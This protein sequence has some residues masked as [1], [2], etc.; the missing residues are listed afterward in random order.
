MIRRDSG[1]SVLVDSVP[2]HGNDWNRG[3]VSVSKLK[4]DE[5]TRRVAQFHDQPDPEHLKIA[6]SQV[7]IM[8]YTSSRF[9]DHCWLVVK[10]LV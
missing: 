9:S 7:A 1:F 10:N 5:R 8:S 2:S 3:G 6:L 4:G